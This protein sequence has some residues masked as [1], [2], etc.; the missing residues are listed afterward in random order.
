MLRFTVLAAFLVAASLW[1]VAQAPASGLEHLDKHLQSEIP[2]WLAAGEH[3]D[4]PWKVKVEKPLETY[5]LRDV[6]RVTALIDAA[7]LQA[8]SV[9]RKL[10]FVIKVANEQGQWVNDQNFVA[11]DLEKTLGHVDLQMES[12]VILKPGKYTIGTIVY[13]SVLNQHNVSLTKWE[14]LPPKKDPL[15]NL[16]R[17]VPDAEFKRGGEVEGTNS[18]VPTR[19]NL[20]LQTSGPV[21]ID[22]LV[23]LSTREEEFH[24][25]HEHN[26]FFRQRPGEHRP[27]PFHQTDDSTYIISLLQSASVLSSLQPQLGCT[28]VSALDAFKERIVVPPSAASDVDWVK[29][30]EQML[31]ASKSTI[32]VKA[33][34]DKKDEPKFL[35]RGLEALTADAPCGAITAKPLHIVIVLSHG[36]HYR[37]GSEKVHAE[38]C[39][40]KVFYLRQSDTVA[41]SDDLRGTLSTLSPKLLDFHDPDGFRQK[42]ADLLRQIEE[43]AK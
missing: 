37:D 13:D 43:L 34:G 10:I 30:K 11:E 5:Q 4:I 2:K 20:P 28:R 12:E 22:L 21:R 29:I 1:S 27:P 7:D 3:Q 33:L 32:D 26:P 39:D 19:A 24:R 14:I 9:Q 31:G 18:L 8:N 42:L 38:A 41:E 6:V 35:L 40:C 36:L 15:P 23:D 25:P 16:L 17:N